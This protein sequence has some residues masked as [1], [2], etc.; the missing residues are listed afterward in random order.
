MDKVENEVFYVNAFSEN[1]IFEALGD[2][3]DFPH[4]DH[5]KLQQGDFAVTARKDNIGVIYFKR[6]GDNQEPHHYLSGQV[7]M[8]YLLLR[9][10][11]AKKAVDRLHYMV[12]DSFRLERQEGPDMDGPTPPIFILKWPPHGSNKRVVW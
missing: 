4:F 1:A 9:P 6:C 2:P 10:G 3:R 11:E 7:I 12:G 5:T 8:T